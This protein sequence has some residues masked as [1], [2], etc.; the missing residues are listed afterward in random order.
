MN[1]KSEYKKWFNCSYLGT[2]LKDE[3]FKIKD[4]ENAIK[5]RFSNFVE[6]GTAGMRGTMGAGLN[7]MNIFT[8]RRTTIGVA[9]FI[10]SCNAEKKG[11]IIT[12][13]SRI[14]SKEFAHY[15]ADV[16]HLQA[17]LLHSITN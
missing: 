2:E 10:K 13:D 4:D 3:L 8:V 9:K 1:Y 14:N 16:L 11:V 12:Y 7:R 17:N 6:F 5:D 15:I